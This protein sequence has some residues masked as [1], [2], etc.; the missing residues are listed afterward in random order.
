MYKIIKLFKI[1][2][3]NS[4]SKIIIFYYFQE[5][6]KRQMKSVKNNINDH[7]SRSRTSISEIEIPISDNLS[8]KSQCPLCFKF[9]PTPNIEVNVINLL[10]SFVYYYY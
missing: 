2:F 6:Q 8:S 4:F 7:M 9:F 1:T 5:L 10:R 3:H